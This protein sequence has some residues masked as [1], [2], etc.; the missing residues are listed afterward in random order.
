MKK[1]LQTVSFLGLALI[2][3]GLSV[4]AQTS[5]TRVN[6]DIP[7]DFAVGGKQLSAGKY[8]LRIKQA[9]LGAK[10]VEI[11]N[12]NREVVYNAFIQD[13]GDRTK[14][15][16]ELKF[17][18]YAGTATLVRIVTE[19]GGYTLPESDRAAQL[20]SRSKDVGGQVSN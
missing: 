4:N 1:F 18:R 16:A 8:V 20:A 2:A 7:F 3:G 6:A 15:N 10:A 12:E 13:N 19:Q 14:D 11:S 9:P 5:A 17:D